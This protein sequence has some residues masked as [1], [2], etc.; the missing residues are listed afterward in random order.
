MLTEKTPKTIPFIVLVTS[1]LLWMSCNTTSNDNVGTS[2]GGDWLIPVQEVVDGG[3]GKDGIPSIENPSFQSV[4]EANFV[5]DERLVIGVKIDEEVRLYPHQVMDWHEIVND[6]INGQHF[7]LTYCPLTGTG[8]AYNRE[9]N[10]EVNEFGVSGLL[11]RN[12]LIMYDRNT[13]SNWSQM[14]LRSVSGNLSG[15]EGE[16]I[17]VVEST[18]KTWKELYPE[19]KVLTTDT[20]FSRNYSGYAYGRG[21]LEN[22]DQFVFQPRRD[23]DRLDNKTIVHAVMENQF[24]G[25]ETV[26][27]IYPIKDLADEVQV[28]QESFRGKNIVF[29]GNSSDQI[30]VSF[31]NLTDD[32]NVLDFEPVQDE[33]PIIMEDS[34][35]NRWNIFGEAVSGPRTGERLTSTRSYNGYWF[36]FADFYPNSCIYPNTVC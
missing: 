3:P 18:W 17:Q 12:N 11:F 35:S 26:M 22:D 9:I 32:G 10:S 30:A 36:A 5:Q 16:I 23:D 28:I 15:E 24:R 2:S 14:Q 8:I 27:R 29:A 1:M 25:E 7:S 20:G 33:L 6:E 31:V 4:N 13:D 21:Y 34:E 19:A